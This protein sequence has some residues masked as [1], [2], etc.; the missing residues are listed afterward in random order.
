[1]FIYWSWDTQQRL[2]GFVP[3][4]RFERIGDLIR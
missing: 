4:P 1:M 2:L 3:T